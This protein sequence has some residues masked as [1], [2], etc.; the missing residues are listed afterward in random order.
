MDVALGLAGIF[1]AFY[2]ILLRP[3]IRQQRARKRD[4]TALEVG[5]EVLTS[6]GFYATVR[7]I[8]TR[9]DGP[10]EIS[11]E[12]APGVKLRATADAIASIVRSAADDASGEAADQ[13]ADR[14]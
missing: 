13:R 2:F 10:L 12:V 11:L 7:A 6:G 9:E 14:A 8:T 4:L 5:D 1:A 3:V